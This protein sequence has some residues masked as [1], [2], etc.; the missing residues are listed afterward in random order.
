M[1]FAAEIEKHNIKCTVSSII[2]RKGELSSKVHRVNEQ[3]NDK[4]KTK[5]I[6]YICNKNISPH[7][8]NKVGAPSQQ[9]G[10]WSPCIKL[11]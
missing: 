5:N 9:K 10:R 6:T 1:K 11:N 2:I 4:L 7:H 8:L 3:L